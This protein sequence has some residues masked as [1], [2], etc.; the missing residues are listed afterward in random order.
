MFGRDESN[1]ALRESHEQMFLEWINLPMQQKKLDLGRHFSTLEDPLPVIVDYL[2]KSNS[3]RAQS[4]ASARDM[5]RE[6]FYTDLEVLLETIK[7][8]LAADRASKPLA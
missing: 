6:L 1:K 2:L 4:P 3:L 5:E 7:N 8:G